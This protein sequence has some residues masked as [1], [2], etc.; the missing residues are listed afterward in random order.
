[1]CGMRLP[2]R[3]VSLAL[4]VLVIRESHLYMPARV[5]LEIIQNVCGFVHR[6][7]LQQ[8]PVFKAAVRV[9]FW[10]ALAMAVTAS[11]GKLVG[12]VV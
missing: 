8:A 7:R 1:M 5:K 2:L 6:Y 12:T 10:G 3:R 4:V 11:V 9:V